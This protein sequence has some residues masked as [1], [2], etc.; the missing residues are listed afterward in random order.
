MPPP[1]NGPDAHV[2][3]SDAFVGRERE[4]GELED[5]LAG[6]GR[7]IMLVGESG[8]G[9]TRT[10]QELAAY[11]EQRGVQVLWGRCHEQADMPPYWPWVQPF[12]TS[13]QRKT[14]E[15]LRRC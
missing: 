4:L 13:I 9:K 15:M 5:A 10:S 2:G 7:M 3:R 14:P 8:I 6:R 12:R 11:A 1:D